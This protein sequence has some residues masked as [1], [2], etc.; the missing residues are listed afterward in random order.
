MRM[1]ITHS[2]LTAQGQISVPAEVQKKLGVGPG[3]MLEW[4]EWNN[5]VV[6]RRAG[7]HSSTDIHSAVF[8]AGPPPVKT[9]AQLKKGIRDL[10]RKR[11]ARK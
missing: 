5:E 11:H 3:S 10:M 4:D 2:R 6:V 1:T 7:K 9:A 8:P